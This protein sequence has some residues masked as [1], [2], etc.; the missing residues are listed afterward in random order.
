MSTEVI[1][2]TLSKANLLTNQVLLE[3]I[4]SVHFNFLKTLYLVATEDSNRYE[5]FQLYLNKVQKINLH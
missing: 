3:K 1:L 5:C 2:C 4:C